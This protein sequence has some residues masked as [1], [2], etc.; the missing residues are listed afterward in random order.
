MQTCIYSSQLYS[1][2][3]HWH[4]DKQHCVSSATFN[5]LVNIYVF[6]VPILP[7]KRFQALL[8][9]DSGILSWLP[10]ESDQGLN[11]IQFLLTYHVQGFNE[12]VVLIIYVGGMAF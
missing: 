10:P 11:P 12:S 3:L 1:P 4:L 2:A 8:S 6:L 7:P 9:T 5:C